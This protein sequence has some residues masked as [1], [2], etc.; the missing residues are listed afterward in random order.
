MCS[1]FSCT[2]GQEDKPDFE[3]G[4][5]DLL[6][7]YLSPMNGSDGEI[8]DHVFPD[9]PKFD[10][11]YS[12][13]RHL[14]DP[15][16]FFGKILAYILLVKCL[17][18]NVFHLQHQ[19]LGAEQDEG[20]SMCNLLRG[21]RT[22]ALAYR[23]G[24]HLDGLSIDPGSSKCR[25]SRPIG[26]EH[27]LSAL[28]LIA[29][30]IADRFHGMYIFKTAAGRYGRTP[31]CPSVGDHVCVVPGGRLLHIISADKSRYVGAASVSG[32][33]RDN[34]PKQDLFPDPEGLFE[35]VVLY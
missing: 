24:V 8:V 15:N 14:T 32:L 25:S 28:L 3:P 10:H 23:C 6:W 5:D 9:C 22:L 2:D 30:S 13:R 17:R 11:E 7:Q 31:R 1:T 33:M 12:F 18:G 4:L 19:R 16:R 34:I 26:E 29:V 21:P 27:I 20:C 35:E